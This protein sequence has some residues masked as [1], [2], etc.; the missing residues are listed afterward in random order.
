MEVTEI[1]I[2]EVTVPVHRI[3]VVYFTK[4]GSPIDPGDVRAGRADTLLSGINFMVEGP[5]IEPIRVLRVI[6]PTLDYTGT[7]MPCATVHMY[8]KDWFEAHVRRMQMMPNDPT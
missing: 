8:A 1:P 6:L 4:A 7:E 2:E 5:G 3:K